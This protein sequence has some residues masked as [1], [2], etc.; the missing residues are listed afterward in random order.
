MEKYFDFIMFLAF[1]VSLN[2]ENKR[3]LTI[4]ELH[5]Y[6]LKLC[7]IIANFY[8]D[9]IIEDSKFSKYL[10]NFIIINKNMK[11]K[12]ER[13]YLKKFLENNDNLFSFDRNIIT[14]NEEITYK[15]IHLLKFE[16]ISIDD[17]YGK[18]ICGDLLSFSDDLEC[19]N[20]LNIST[21]TNDIKKL[22]EVEKNIEKE[23]QNYNDMDAKNKIRIGM[24]FIINKFL[25]ISKMSR[26]KSLCYDKIIDNYNI[27]ENNEIISEEIQS[28]E[29]YL[30]NL[31]IDFELENK[32]QRAIFGNDSLALDQLKEY[33]DALW[34]YKKIDENDD[35]IVND[36][37]TEYD[38]ELIIDDEE[39]YEEDY[40]DIEEVYEDE[41]DNSKNLF[42]VKG[43]Q[44]IIKIN[45]IFYLNYIKIVDNYQNKFGLK[46][47]LEKCKARLLFLL[48]AY[49][50]NL[51][52][53]QNLETLIANISIKGIDLKNDF[54]DFCVMSKLFLID[55]LKE[56]VDDE[57]NLR[58]ILFVANYYSL[59]KDKTIA[60]LINSYKNSTNY[61]KVCKA[62]FSGYYNE[63]EKP[64]NKNKL[65][66]KK[67]NIE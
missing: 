40:E 39:E 17:T 52:E 56:Y 50:Y 58:K 16:L 13:K 41:S 62:I 66:K 21:I 26:E 5:N 33:N 23:Y 65:K 3:S 7:E 35:E 46:D 48:D 42:L 27:L 47:D 1:E 29:F 63:F 64:L 60:E 59:T 22:I 45:L 31:A 36:E 9:R 67:S 49:G 53:Q 25:Q 12:E 32:F 10:K 44:E 55:I 28:N 30:G 6:R 24:C 20:L 8:S 4:R 2:Y 43:Y 57:L 38:D 18:L 37:E 34:T 15:K 51:Y 61:L 54:N 11:N 19:L 14:L